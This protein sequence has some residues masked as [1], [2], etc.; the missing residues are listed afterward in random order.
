MDANLEIAQATILAGIIAK[1]DQAANVFST[2]RI[3]DFDGQYRLIAE[4]IHGLRIA[5]TTIDLLAV[6]DEMTRRGTIGRIGGQSEL[7][8]VAGFDF[9]SVDYSLEI[10]GRTAQLR[11][12]DV[13][14]L[15]LHQMSE[16]TDAD[17][18]LIARNMV[19]TGQSVIDR[20]EAEGDITTLT[21]GEFLAVEDRPSDWVIPG[22]LERGD[23]LILTGSEGL[24]K[25]VLFRQLAV[26]A[27]SGVHPF[28]LRP[29][30]PQRVLYVDCENG[31]I[32]LRKALR[33]LV[34]QGIARGTDPSE[35]LFIEA[36]PEGLDLTTAEDELWLVKRVSALQPSLLL[37]GPLYR[38]HAKDP[39]AEEPQRAVA[40]VLD[41]C[42]AAANCALVVEGHAGHGYGRDAERPVRPTGSSL[43]LR[44]P[45]FG[46]GIRAA[47]GYTP[48][49]R[50]VDFVPWR[51]DRSERDWPQRLR[52]GGAW[53]WHAE[54]TNP[55][56]AFERPAS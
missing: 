47:E 44:W 19:E 53:P 18:Y 54:E 41:R 39:N 1:P 7:Y 40:R 32:Q 26:A 56:N 21:V 28:T 38:L 16:T 20:I 48:Q 37:T 8:R 49:D 24:G 6:I 3:E 12:L 2:V 27:A 15:R 51:G 34:H 50:V 29:I 43:W 4:A 13:A 52:S 33:P 5:R 22:L 17:P 42:R 45:E 31:T 14:S 46:Y 55:H 9:G 11:R 10:V 25:S 36:R 23:R 35:S 30:A